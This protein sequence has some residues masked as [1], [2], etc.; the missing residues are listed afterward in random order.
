MQNISQR[1]GWG[2]GFSMSSWML[3]NKLGN[4]A[5]G[6]LCKW[7]RAAYMKDTFV[8]RQRAPVYAWL[9]PKCGLSLGRAHEPPGPVFPVCWTGQLDW[10]SIIHSQS[11][12]WIFLR[13]LNRLV[14][15]SSGRWGGDSEQF[16]LP[17]EVNT[18]LL[19]ELLRFLLNS[20]SNNNH[21]LL[22]PYCAKFM[23]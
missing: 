20:C 12:R 7:W 19:S 18:W 22:F 10:W 1:R 17:V 8:L 15:F 23:L 6:A 13:Q 16:F 21:P 9:S 5:E 4:G 2:K 14:L 11:R 3:Y